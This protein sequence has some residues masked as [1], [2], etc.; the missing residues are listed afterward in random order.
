MEGKEFRGGK[1]G[2]G[3]DD[4]GK[5]LSEREQWMAGKWREVGDVEVE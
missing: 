4:E 1:G 3:R 2:G 5:E